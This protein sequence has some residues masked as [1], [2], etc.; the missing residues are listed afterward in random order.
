MGGAHPMGSKTRSLTVAVRRG[1]ARLPQKD[2]V[3]SQLRPHRPRHGLHSDGWRGYD[4]LVDVGYAKLN[5]V[6]RHTFDPRLKE[7]E[8]R[9]NRRR[10]NLYP[11]MLKLFRKPPSVSWPKV[12]VAV[13]GA[14]PMVESALGLADGVV[15]MIGRRMS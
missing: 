12:K 5:D 15:C 1:C 11:V 7:T 6:P 2:L 14:S 3:K 10:G 13:Y 4:G 9:F 8:F